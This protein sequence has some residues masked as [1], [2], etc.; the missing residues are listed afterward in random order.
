MRIRNKKLIA[1]PTSIAGQSIHKSRLISIFRSSC[2]F[3]EGRKLGNCIAHLVCKTAVGAS[4]HLRHHRPAVI[5][6]LEDLGIPLRSLATWTLKMRGWRTL[7]GASRTPG[8]LAA[9]SGERFSV[10]DWTRHR[11]PQSSLVR[12]APTGSCPG[13]SSWLSEMGLLLDQE[14]RVEKGK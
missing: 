13:S 8:F 9:I 2:G 14:V 10:I 4:R 11:F 5:L 7:A 3:P 1:E 12:R 6:G